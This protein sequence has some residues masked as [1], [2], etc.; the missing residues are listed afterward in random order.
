MVK[1]SCIIKRFTRARH[2]AIERVLAMA[3][4]LRLCLT[5]LGVLSKQLD[6]PSWFLSWELPS[7]YPT[8][9]CKEI[10]TTSKIRVLPSGNLLKTLYLENFAT[11]YRSSK[12]VI[13]LARERWTLRAR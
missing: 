6:K 7:T 5:Q 1:Y 13:K 11:A 3:L 12:P 8:L 4:C 9:C 10:Q 2:Y